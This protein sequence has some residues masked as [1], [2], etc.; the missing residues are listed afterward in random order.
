ML[1]MIKFKCVI[2]QRNKVIIINISISF[3]LSVHSVFASFSTESHAVSVGSELGD[4]HAVGDAV[5]ET[6]SGRGAADAACISA[7]LLTALR[8]IIVTVL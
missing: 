6:S 7:V 3:V 4:S 5:I 1:L 8:V 2:T